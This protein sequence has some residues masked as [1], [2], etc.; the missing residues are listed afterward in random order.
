[1][2]RIT[3]ELDDDFLSFVAKRKK[4]IPRK[5]K[6]LAVLELYRRKEISSGKAAQLLGMERFEFIRY[7]SRLEIPFFDISKRE[8]EQDVATARKVADEIK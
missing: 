8:L 5:L 4:D 2:K 7:A 3:I 6:E 1:M